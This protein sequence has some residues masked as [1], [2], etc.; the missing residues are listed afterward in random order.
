MKTK[1]LTFKNTICLILSFVLL[2]LS[3]VG[4]VNITKS[5]NI[6]YGATEASLKKISNSNFDENSHSYYPYK[7]S[8]YNYVDKNFNTV[9]YDPQSSSSSV[10]V[11]AGVISLEHKDYETVYPLNPNSSDKKVLMIKNDKSTSTTFGVQ[12][13]TEIELKAGSNYSI[14]ADVLTTAND[15]TAALYLVDENGDIFAEFKNL[16]SYNRWTPYTFFIKTNTVETVKVKLTM[17][18]V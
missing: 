17:F 11:K 18:L 8:S 9:E 10:N 5:N 7:P 1:K 14:S 2:V 6:V 15:G 13:T 4:I 12:S 16:N 3:G